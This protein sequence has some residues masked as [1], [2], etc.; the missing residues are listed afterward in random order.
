MEILIRWRLLPRGLNTAME[1][2][3]HIEN[4]ARAMQAGAVRTWAMN[5]K[6][7]KVFTRYGLEAEPHV[8]M[9]KTL[10]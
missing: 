7:A 4:W 2:W 8:L 6:L 1:G 3:E 5:D 10:S 9:E